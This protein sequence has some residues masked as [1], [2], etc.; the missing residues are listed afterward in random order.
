MSSRSSSSTRAAASTR[1]VGTRRA[2]RRA[3]RRGRRRAPARPRR[4]LP[5]S[6]AARRSC[7]RAAAGRRPGGADAGAAARRRRAGRLPRLP[8][9]RAL[10]PGLRGSAWPVLA[11]PGLARSSA[12][13]AGPPETHHS[14]A[15]GLLKHTVGVATLCPRT[16]AAPSAAALRPA[17]RGGA[18]ARRRPHPRATGQAPGFPLT[19]EGRLLGHVHLG[20]RLIEERAVSST[21]RAGRAAPRGRVPPRRR[22]ARTA[23]AACCT[24]RTSWTRSPRP[25]RWSSARQRRVDHD[26]AGQE[27]GVAA[28]RRGA[29]RS[30]GRCRRPAV[31]PARRRRSA[32]ERR[33]R[34]QARRRPGP[35]RR[36]DEHSRVAL[37]RRHGCRR[38]GNDRRRGRD[39]NLPRRTGGG[40]HQRA[41]GGGAVGLDRAARAAG[42]ARSGTA[43]D[44]PASHWSRRPRSMRSR[45]RWAT[46]R[47]SRP[48]KPA[49]TFDFLALAGNRVSC[50]ETSKHA[51]RSQHA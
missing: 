34:R 4:A 21:K 27:P 5:R 14:Y 32:A 33:A 10:T 39:C 20:L 26:R 42:A 24:T 6:A 13:T 23:E 16:R 3:F 45:P 2:A 40:A 19:E 43:T 28:A 50:R 30:R 7:P 51:D 49:I 46:P 37:P 35:L 29:A 17:A 44:P 11:D 8:R 31:L 12:R 36:D 41:L 47:R 25:G 48:T 22:A 1:R 15:G 38:R 18:A 9:R